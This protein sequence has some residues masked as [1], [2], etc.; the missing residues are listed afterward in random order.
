MS[1]TRQTTT[2]APAA[3]AGPVG[4]VSRPSFKRTLTFFGFFAI[5]ASMVMTVYEYPSFASSGFQLVF[6]LI[7]GGV[8]WFLP[9]ALCAAEMATVKGWESGGIFAWVGNTLGRRWG[10]AALF[11]QWFQ[12]TV[13]FVTMAFFILA[14][15]AYVVKWDALYSNPLVM[16][17]GVAAIVWLL[18]LTQLGGTK[19]TARISKVG[20]VGGIIVPVIV[21]LVGLLI[22]FATGGVSQITMDPATFVPDFG[23]VDTLVIFASFILAYMGV[24]A[25]ASHVNELKNPNRNYPLAMIVLAILTIALD[26]LGGLAVATT[27]PQ[28]VLDS[29]L[30][31]GVI[32]A[33]RAI[34]VTHISP[35]LSWIVFVVAL[36]L[37]LGVLAEI[38]AW[39]VGPSRAL[40]DTAHD[41]I[42]PPTFKKVNKN[43]VSV[44][45]VVIQAIIVTAWDAVLCGS[46]ALS[47]G[48]SSSVGYLTAIGLTVVIYLV[49]YVLFF[50]GYFVL[51]LKKKNLQRSFQLPG[52]TPFKLIVAGVGLVMTVATLIISF[53]PSSN[54][55]A[56]SNAVYQATLG[57]S[58]VVSVALPF[59]IYALRHRWSGPDT[60]VPV[61]AAAGAGG[62]AAV[63]G[64]TRAGAGAMNAAELDAD[65]HPSSP[66]TADP[67]VGAS[68][69]ATSSTQQKGGQ[70][71][72][73]RT[74]SQASLHQS[75]LTAGGMGFGGMGSFGSVTTRPATPPR[76]D[77]PTGAAS[78]EG[79]P[80]G[81]ATD[82]EHEVDVAR[83]P[84]A[85]PSPGALDDF[86]DNP[87]AERLRET[88]SLWPEGE[89]G[90]GG[91][92]DRAATGQA[93][94]APTSAAGGSAP[95]DAADVRD[96]LIDREAEGDPSLRAS[97]TEGVVGQG[98]TNADPDTSDPQRETGP[99]TNHP[100]R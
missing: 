79:M 98:L 73:K 42:L 62:A 46:I 72:N 96:N 19:Y 99:D 2:V 67:R 28:T 61:G 3:D 24:E 48:S 60:A 65:A 13:G 10:F 84:I 63:A 71:M 43:G 41:G 27:L 75:G 58:F 5:T 78:Q 81:I 45:T 23:K 92:G 20:F 4:S 7:I 89:G 32:E 34:Y 1:E 54:L 21:L 51:V 64:R 37:A 66:T 11:F 6:F 70:R 76:D 95:K 87:P 68:P 52:G 85:A 50:L 86:A 93:G 26:A 39:I 22:Y 12:I 77:A 15:F 17:F 53:F 82:H 38:S 100:A 25:S 57:V 44:K 33:F 83:E 59:I 91:Q 8:L 16:F 18:T 29:N 55:D 31:F 35:A 74:R 90:Q 49:G 69:A 47:G 30:S 97:V 56:Q 40:L 94:S 80:Q 14:A 88:G 36:L 9:V